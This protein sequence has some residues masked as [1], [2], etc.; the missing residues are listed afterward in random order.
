[1]IFFSIDW[2]RIESIFIVVVVVVFCKM[3]LHQFYFWRFSCTIPSFFL[4]FLFFVSQ[5]SFDEFLWLLLLVFIFNGKTEKKDSVKCN[6]NKKKKQNP[7]V[8]DRPLQ[9]FVFI[10]IIQ[11]TNL[12]SLLMMMFFSWGW[13]LEKFFVFFLSFKWK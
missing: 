9:S 1:M 10:F 11:L 3:F 13:I 6:E 2:F 12:H 5:F 8:N 7:S 4:L